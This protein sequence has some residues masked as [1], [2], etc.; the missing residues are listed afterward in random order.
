MRSWTPRFGIVALLFTAAAGCGL[1]HTFEIRETVSVDSAG[2]E[3]IQPVDLAA[4][5]GDAWSERKKID[6]VKVKSATATITSVGAGNT[7]P[8]GGGEAS[9][10]R[11]SDPADAVTFAQASGIPIEVGQSYAA[12]NLGELSAVIRRGLKGDGQLEIV[13]A[14]AAD[15]GVAQFDAEIVVRVEVTFHL[16]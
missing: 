10:R 4:I 7:A 15:S 3:T 16:F 11:S 6:T 14:R 1:D 5:A 12:Q 8:S 9:L 2:A 13:A